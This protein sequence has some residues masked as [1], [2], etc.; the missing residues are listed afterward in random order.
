MAQ[1]SWRCKKRESI[2][3]VNG[4]YILTTDTTSHTPPDGIHITDDIMNYSD[5]DSLPRPDS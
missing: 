4:G 3:L 5:C 2:K 1:Q